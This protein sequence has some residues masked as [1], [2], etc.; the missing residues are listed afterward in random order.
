MKKFIINSGF[1]V[2]KYIKSLTENINSKWRFSASMKSMDQ[3][4]VEKS[5]FRYI[6]DIVIEEKVMYLNVHEKVE[7]TLLN[8]ITGIAITAVSSMLTGKFYGNNIGRVIKANKIK[9]K[10]TEISENFTHEYINKNS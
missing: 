1:D 4:E 3:I 10:I 6:I 9:E 2:E 7:S 8:A 5:S